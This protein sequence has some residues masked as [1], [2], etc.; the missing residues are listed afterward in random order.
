MNFHVCTLQAFPASFNVCGQ[1]QEPTLEWITCK[2]F[3]F[4]KILTYPQILFY[5]GKSCRG[6]T[7]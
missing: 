4:G 3:K 7:L 5:P 1:G 6:Q 2:V